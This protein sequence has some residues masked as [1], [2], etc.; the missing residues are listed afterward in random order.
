MPATT[1]P[2]IQQAF[3]SSAGAGYINNPIPVAS[4]IGVTPGAASYTDGF[5][6]LTMT[7]ATAGGVNPF[8]QDFNG[9]LFA[10]SANIAALSGGQNYTFNSTWATA[11]GGYAVGAIVAMV[12]G[13]G[14]WINQSSGNTNNPDTSAP[15]SGWY[16]L[17]CYGETSI[18]GLT[19]ANVT[20][21]SQQA[22]TPVIVLSGTLTSNIN[23]VFPTWLYKWVVINNTSGSY[24][25][26]AKTSSGTGVSIAQGGASN[27]TLIFGDGTN[28]QSLFA[29]FT[30]GTN[31]VKFPTGQIMQFGST[32]MTSSAPGTRVTFPKTFPTSC[33]SV[34]LTPLGSNA[35]VLVLDQTTTYFDGINGVG[36]TNN[37]VAFGY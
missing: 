16:P 9:I 13:Q 34:Q 30:S 20:L 35:T 3:G 33:V 23:I 27:A 18:A 17:A 19:N 11:N 29:P 31:W 2:L 12:S 8:G 5:P 21:S 1:P 37:W 26:T 28:I 15:S 24:T 14:Y 4:Q 10:L 32:A 6:P 7:P 22:C 36:G 25:I